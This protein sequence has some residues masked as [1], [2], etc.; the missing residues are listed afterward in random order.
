MANYFVTGATGFIGRGV[1]ARLAAGGD[2]VRCLTRNP[3][4]V[5]GNEPGICW[6]RGELNDPDRYREVLRDTDYV[7]HLAALLHAR[8]RED[9]LGVNVG[10]TRALL[11]ACV[12]SEAPLK[13]FVCMS[14][15][16]AM[17]PVGAGRLLVET[18][19]CRPVSEYG[20]SKFLAERVVLETERSFPVSILRPSFVYGRKDR[21]GAG[22]VLSLLSGSTSLLF[23]VVEAVSLCHVTDVVESCL[24]AAG[25]SLPRDKVFIISDPV[26]Y[27]WTEI[28]DAL[29][30][31]MLELADGD[32]F[33]RTTISSTCDR[34]RR[35]LS[36]AGKA[37][38][39]SW[40]C[41]T[42]KS[43]ERLGFHPGISL[44]EGLRDTVQGYLNM[45][46]LPGIP[47]NSLSTHHKQDTIHHE[48]SR[49]R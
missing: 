23:R 44:R 41:D 18:G 19:R 34:A 45:G 15:I 2:Q 32:L 42:K 6:I 20:R 13:E 43:R 26:A 3:P 12:E 40:G 29:E 35:A 30:G 31:V 24:R 4:D 38:A 48:K 7:L 28:I 46:W 47:G 11:Q 10:G 5:R 27:T 16:A 37:R 21:R 14:S 8:R 36:E 22:Y 33:R 17:G 1:V 9:Y 39:I 25:A 49:R